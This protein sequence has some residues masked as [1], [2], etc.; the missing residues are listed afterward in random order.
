MSRRKRTPDYDDQV[1]DL[2]EQAD[3]LPEGPAKVAI[4][5]EAVALADLHR[6]IPLA[7]ETRMAMLWPAYHASRQDLLLVHFAWCLAQLDANDE[8]DAHNALW[9][10]RWVLD[11]MPGFSDIPRGRIADAIADMMRRYEEFGVSLRP[12]YLLHRRVYR[13]LGDRDAAIAAHKKIAKTK[14]DWLCDDLETERAFAVFFA[15]FLEKHAEALK[16]AEKLL[17]E[18]FLTDHFRGLIMTDILLS[19]CRRDHWERAAEFQKLSLPMLKKQRQSSG[20][21]AVHTEYLSVVGDFAAA[22]RV[23]EGHLLEAGTEPNR[24]TRFDY[25]RAGK[26]LC[27]RLQ[28]SGKSK[29]KIRV[30]DVLEIPGAE[31]GRI[32]NDLLL[33]WL[34]EQL[35]DLVARFDARNGTPFFAE[36]LAKMKGLTELAAKYAER[37]APVK[38]AKPKIKKV[39]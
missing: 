23:F 15:V 10:Y 22:V 9:A 30:P 18:R 34:D 26:F 27:T 39:P 2:V 32:R 7:Y 6:D 20:N 38:V 11:T 13:G 3:D 4:Y 37:S 31:A 28:S 35:A 33:A 12:C 21:F 14:Y 19:L 29:A 24:I 17:T 5:E 1:N 16:L 36:E 25:Y 8:L